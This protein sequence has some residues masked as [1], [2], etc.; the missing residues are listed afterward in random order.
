ME[1]TNKPAISK[2]R[3]KNLVIH[4]C[5]QTSQLQTEEENETEE[6]ERSERVKKR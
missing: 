6:K 5:F 3:I 4:H 2:E 1:R